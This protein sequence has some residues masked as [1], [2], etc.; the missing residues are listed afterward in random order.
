MNT[1]E[2]MSL[3]EFQEKGYLQEVLNHRDNN[4]PKSKILQQ[5]T[6]RRVLV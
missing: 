1:M 3:Q 2:K 6:D 5:Q 4:L